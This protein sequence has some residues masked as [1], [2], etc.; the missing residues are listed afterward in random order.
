MIGARLWRPRFLQALFDSMSNEIP[1]LGLIPTQHSRPGI[2]DSVLPTAPPV[3]SADG[4]RVNVSLDLREKR[5]G[6]FIKRGSKELASSSWS[7]GHYQAKVA[8][9]AAGRPRHNREGNLP[10]TRCSRRCA[11]AAP[12]VSG[13]A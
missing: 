8:D 11:N 2:R 10:L 5:P 7:G 13:W 6:H 1:N 4:R 9:E 12:G 3:V